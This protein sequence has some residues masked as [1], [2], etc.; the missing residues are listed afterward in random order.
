MLNL[1]GLANLIF[2]AFIIKLF[3][4]LAIRPQKR[5]AEAHRELISAI[6]VGDDVVTIGGMHGT[7]RR[8]ADDE[9]ELE[10]SPGTNVRF[11]KQAVAR[12]VTDEDTAAGT[13]DSASTSEDPGA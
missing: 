11:L 2:L 7:V 13:S 8:I 1:E 5:R 12:R 4:F 6:S 9:V 3:Y 10:V